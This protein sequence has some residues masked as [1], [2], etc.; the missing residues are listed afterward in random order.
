MYY[1]SA[2]LACEAA[3]VEFVFTH[4]E[5]LC[6]EDIP[7]FLA[8]IQENL[9]NKHS[10]IPFLT[11]DSTMEQE[12]TTLFCS[13]SALQPLLATIGRVATCHIKRRYIE[14]EKREWAKNF[15]LRILSVYAESIIML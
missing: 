3:Y 15:I 9:N 8:F 1:L 5:E 11:K 4:C 2:L 6:T 14:K 12:K 10:C 7:A 13:E